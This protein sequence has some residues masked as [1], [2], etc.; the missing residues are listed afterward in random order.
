MREMEGRILELESQNEELDLES[1]EGKGT[2]A[3]SDIV[4]LMKQMQ[5]DILKKCSTNTE[6][7]S[8]RGDM[9]EIDQNVSRLMDFHMKRNDLTT[10]LDQINV[11]AA[12]LKDM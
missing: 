2:I 7:S 3:I 5:V 9:K 11:M 10:T 1:L 8:L 6:I 12:K 4:G